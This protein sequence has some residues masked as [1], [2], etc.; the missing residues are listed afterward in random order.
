[1]INFLLEWL[2]NREKTIVV[3]QLGIELNLTISSIMANMEF[4][5][6]RISYQ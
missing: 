5:S 6:E 3:V 4:V 2:W 1:M